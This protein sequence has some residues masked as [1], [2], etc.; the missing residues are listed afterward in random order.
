LR[1]HGLKEIEGIQ[2][3]E[4]IT[5]YPKEFFNPMNNNTGKVDIT[6]NTH[7]IHR[8]SMSWIDPKQKARSRVTR[9]FH[10]IFGEN[11]FGFLKG[12]IQ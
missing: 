4:G 7:S 1:R 3:V 9:I 8:Y 12:I 11:C 6:E 10:R 2:K 5:I